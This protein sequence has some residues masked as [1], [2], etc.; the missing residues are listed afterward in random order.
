MTVTTTTTADVREA[1]AG[2]VEAGAVEGRRWPLQP[3]LDACGL[4]SAVLAAHLHVGG[5]AV[6]LAARSGLSDRQADRWAIRLGFHPLLVWGWAWVDAAGVPDMPHE[7]VAHELRGQ[8][9]RGELRAGEPLPTVKALAALFGVG[10]K[11]I[12]RAAAELNRDGLVTTGGRGQ[13]PVV[14]HQAQTL[15]EDWRTC[16]ECGQP[17]EPGTEHYPHPPG[18]TLATAG[19]CDCDHPTHPECCPTCPPAVRR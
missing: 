10:D 6:T 11:A 5:N 9:E 15:P 17:I 12:A 1:G 19:W 2:D 13:R 16:G 18:C 4:T 3:L 7:R 14:A 8:I